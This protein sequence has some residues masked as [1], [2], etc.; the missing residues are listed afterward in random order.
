MGHQSDIFE[1]V[2]SHMPWARVVLYKGRKAVERAIASGVTLSG[3]DENAGLV[4]D[5]KGSVQYLTSD[6]IGLHRGDVVK[7]TS[8]SSGQTIQARIIGITALGEVRKI[9]IEGKL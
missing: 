1:Q 8:A 3:A 6:D 7:I 4:I 5:A 9:N 2:Y